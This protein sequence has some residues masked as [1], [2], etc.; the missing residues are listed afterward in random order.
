MTCSRWRS[1]LGCPAAAAELGTWRQAVC[2]AEL[3]LRHAHAGTSV[4]V[5]SGDDDFVCNTMGTGKWVNALLW[6]RQQAWSG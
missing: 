1:L 2:T 5:Y 3:W 4:L 6:S